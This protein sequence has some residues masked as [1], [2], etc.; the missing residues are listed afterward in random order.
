MKVV[1]DHP[2]VRV[3]FCRVQR[4]NGL[5][6]ILETVAYPI[7]HVTNPREALELGGV[8]M[9]ATT[10]HRQCFDTAGVFN[11]KNLT[12]QDTEMSL[13]LATAFPFY[14]KSHRRVVLPRALGA[15]NS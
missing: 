5:G 6:K 11:E 8:N 9:C 10:I 14:L 12:A 1:H 13:R 4:I 7:E 2:E 3:I 15:R